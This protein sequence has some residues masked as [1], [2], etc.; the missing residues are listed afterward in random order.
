MTAVRSWSN[1]PPRTTE[2]ELPELRLGATRDA[3]VHC[4]PHSF[5]QLGFL[6]GLII[7]FN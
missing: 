4:L 7:G 6:S 2:E 1:V 3:Y 5:E